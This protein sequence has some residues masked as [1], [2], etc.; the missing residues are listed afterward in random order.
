MTKTLS[1]TLAEV[2]LFGSV[3]LAQGAPK[4]SSPR[5]AITLSCAGYEKLTAD[6]DMIGALSGIKKL[7]DRIAKPL[8]ML[9][10]AHRA[11]GCLA[12]AP[13]EPWGAV[14]T[15][16]GNRAWDMYAFF[17]ATDVVPLVELSSI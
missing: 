17:P 2:V 10:E 15:V 7:S 11:K 9:T 13:K 5:P 3:C 6:I 16:I 12:L 4:A 14:F 8:Q 1:L